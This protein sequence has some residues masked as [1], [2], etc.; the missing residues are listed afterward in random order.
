MRIV[1][2]NSHHSSRVSALCGSG[3]GQSKGEQG[4]Q[5]SAGLASG[6]VSNDRH[7][8]GSVA[9]MQE[10]TEKGN[11]PLAHNRSGAEQRTLNQSNA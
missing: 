4:T 1:K 9:R 11:Q 7:S 10:A 5:T 8:I 3:I 6:G 2:V